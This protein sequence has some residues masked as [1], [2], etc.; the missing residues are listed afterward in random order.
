MTTQ[1]HKVKL[2]GEEFE[3]Y[4]KEI[5]ELYL[6]FCEMKRIKE[7]A[8]S[9]GIIELIIVGGKLDGSKTIKTNKSTDKSK[10]VD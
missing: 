1:M 5:D 4:G 3:F 8:Y 2:C 10:D 7:A 9:C 6:A